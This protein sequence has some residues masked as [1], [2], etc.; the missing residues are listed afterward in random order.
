[1]MIYLKQ[2]FMTSICP[3]YK[4]VKD[5]MTNCGQSNP[6]AQN[7]ETYY[8]GPIITGLRKT[9][10]LSC[11]PY[12]FYHGNMY[13]AIVRNNT[14]VIVG[15]SFGDIYVNNLINRMH[16]IWSGKERIVLI[17]KWDETKINNNERLLEQYIY[18]LSHG[19]REFLEIM[20]GCNDIS[21]MIKDFISP[22]IHKAQYASNGNLLLVTS[23]MKEASTIRNEIY[24]F[25]KS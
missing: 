12:D 23:G 7:N 6:T 21:A 14:L 19:E 2:T 4:A 3:N 15:Y 20:S 22:D 9:D 25:L 10:K 18:T 8:A 17:D 5:R 13:N 11:M 16:G 1:M 24:D